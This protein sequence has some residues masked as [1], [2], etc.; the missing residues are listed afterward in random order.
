[1]RKAFPQ[2]NSPTPI[3]AYILDFNRLQEIKAGRRNQVRQA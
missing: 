1:M 3:L 2:L